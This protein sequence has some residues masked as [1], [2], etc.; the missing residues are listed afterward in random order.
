MAVYSWNKI[1]PNLTPTN[2]KDTVSI[3]GVTGTF[4]GWGGM[5][6]DSNIWYSLV[7]DWDTSWTILLAKRVATHP[8]KVVFLEL[9]HTRVWAFPSQTLNIYQYDSTTMTQDWEFRSS[10]WALGSVTTFDSAYLDWNIIH[11]NTS[12]LFPAALYHW[13]YNVLTNAFTQFTW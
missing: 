4:T 2:I 9:L 7:T 1:D 10:Y 12:A 5:I 8:S 6:I 3:F 11:F 13:D